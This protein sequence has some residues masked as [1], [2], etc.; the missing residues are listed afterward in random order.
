MRSASRFISQPATPSPANATTDFP[1]IFPR[2]P[3]QRPSGYIWNTFRDGKHFFK[4]SDSRRTLNCKSVGD[5]A[6]DN[7]DK[8]TCLSSGFA[9]E[10]RAKR[11]A[12]KWRQPAGYLQERSDTQRAGFP[13]LHAVYLLLRVSSQL[14][15]ASQPGQRSSSS[16]PELHPEVH[17]SR[18]WPSCSFRRSFEVNLID[19]V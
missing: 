18:P 2:A 17:R 6:P 10:R 12:Q 19:Q 3:L 14:F 9:S 5:F 7:S 4:Q 11:C 16:I 1:I 13:A 8:L 15:K